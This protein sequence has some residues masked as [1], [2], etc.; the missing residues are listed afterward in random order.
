MSV[1]PRKRGAS[2]TVVEGNSTVDDTDKGSGGCAGERYSAAHDVDWSILMAHAQD[3]DGDS[4][5]RLLEE[6]APYLRYLAARVHRDTSDIEDAVQDVLLTIH[7]IRHTYDP[8]RPFGPWLVAIV[9]RRLTDRLRRQG[10]R[11]RRETALTIEHEAL[12]VN[13][14]H[15]SEPIDHGKLAAAIEHLPPRQRQAITLL[16]LEELSLKEAATATG[17][18]VSSLKI[19]THRALQRLRKLL[20]DR[21][22]P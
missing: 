17:I 5:R 22:K 8:R 10:N 9:R 15:A 13:N 7:A 21:S 14:A 12:P 16:K 18:S 1:D 4:Y 11:R 6:V 2:L 19:A 20:A 3:G